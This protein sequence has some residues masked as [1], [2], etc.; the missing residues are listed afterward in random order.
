MQL[1]GRQ[2]VVQRKMVLLLVLIGISPTI[3]DWSDIIPE[4]MVPAAR[5]LR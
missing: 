5:H 3:S 2:K 1:C 4:A